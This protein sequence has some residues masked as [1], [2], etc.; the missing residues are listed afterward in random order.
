L[1]KI[2]IVKKMVRGVNPLTFFFE[3]VSGYIKPNL[4]IAFSGNPIVGSHL[5]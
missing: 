4:K 1:G 5:Q 2:K 3:V